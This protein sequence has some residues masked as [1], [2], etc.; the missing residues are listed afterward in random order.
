MKTPNL[1]NSLSPLRENQFTTQ[2]SVEFSLWMSIVPRMQRSRGIITHSWSHDSI[3]SVENGARI[4]IEKIH[5]VTI[6]SYQF[7]ISS[8]E[9]SLRL[10]DK[11]LGSCYSCCSLAIS[12]N[13]W[14]LQEYAIRSTR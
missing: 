1:R 5:E 4:R 7:Y 2:N 8:R 9:I 13:L 10:L 6:N 11:H 14:A 3:I 12:R